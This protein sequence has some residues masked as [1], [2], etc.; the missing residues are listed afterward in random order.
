LSYTIRRGGPGTATAARSLESATSTAPVAGSST[1]N[2]TSGVS[3]PFE[4]SG[5]ITVSRSAGASGQRS[6][7]PMRSLLIAVEP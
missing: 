1:E 3:A 2:C 7:T 6:I 5:V 4:P